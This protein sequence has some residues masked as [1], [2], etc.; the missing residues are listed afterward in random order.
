MNKYNNKHL[1]KWRQWIKLAQDRKGEQDEAYI[2]SQ[3]WADTGS[4]DRYLHATTGICTED[5]FNNKQPIYHSAIL[6][7][8]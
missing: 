3:Q 2:C 4:L 5:F 1:N 7:S 6:W 8:T